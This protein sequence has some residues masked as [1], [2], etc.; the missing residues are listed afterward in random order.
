[1][2]KLLAVVLSAMLGV[3]L[4]GQAPSAVPAATFEVASIKP[5]KSGGVNTLFG[6]QG[7]R[8]TATNTT[9]RELIRLTYQVRDLQLLGAPDWIASERFDIFAKATAPLKSGAIPAELKQ[10]LSDRVG[11]KVHS[12]SRELPIYALV[13]ARADGTLGPGLQPIETDRCPEAVARAEARARSGQ[14]SP[15]STPGQRMTCGLRFN[16]GSFNGGSI[17]LAPLAQSLSPVVGR[18]VVDRT[19]LAG[20]FDFDL[21]WASDPT[22]DST[23]PSIFTALQEQLGLK[24]ESTRGPVDVVVIDQV[25]PLTPD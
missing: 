22:A 6:I 17:G 11:L 5:N 4:H 8:F 1:M 14:P 15:P 16:P 9:L 24:L 10:L 7:D 25:A 18:V 19:G 20:K 13:V 3:Q 21:T 12:E 2:S 23:G